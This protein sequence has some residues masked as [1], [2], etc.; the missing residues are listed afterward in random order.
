[1][2]R[3]KPGTSVRQAEAVLNVAAQRI[4]SQHS[5]VDKDISIRAFPENRARPEPDA[6]NSLVVLAAA[7]M[8]L[9]LLADQFYGV[10]PSDPIT[11]AGVAI[12]L[13]G[14]ALG[15]SLIPAYRATRVRPLDALRIE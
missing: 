1:M 8:G 11:Y 12:L 6:D 13:V 7:F 5:D 10:A 14:V 4:A 2:G 3:L 15:A 9:A